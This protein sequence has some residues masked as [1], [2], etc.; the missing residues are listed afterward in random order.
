V[1]A[2]SQVGRLPSQAVAGLYRPVTV[3]QWRLT[4]SPLVL[5]PGYWSAARLVENMAVLMRDDQVWMSLTP[6]EFESQGL[7]LVFAQGHVAVL[8]LGLGW[9]A[10]ECALD[11]AV[12]GVTI[13]ERDPEVIA[14]HRELDLFARLPGHC[15]AKVKIVQDDAL[16]WRPDQPVDL[17]MPDI[18]LPLVS[19]QDRAADVRQMQANI[20]ADAVYFWGQELEI[21]RQCVARGLALDDTG[22]AATV[23]AMGLPLVGPGTPDYS[24]RLIAAAKA[25]MRGRWLPGS[26][27]P[28]E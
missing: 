25:W 18:W 4:I 24:A 8:G 11:P 7:G 1:I 12:T 3:G 28:F 20:A 19:A 21:A 27:N 23:A 14:L 5:C 22:I 26:E 6:L 16:A 13:V 9:V 17:L 10:A 2:V 15:G